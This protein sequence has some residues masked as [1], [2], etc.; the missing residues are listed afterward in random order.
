MNR[1]VRKEGRESRYILW[2]NFLVKDTRS[3]IYHH[4]RQEGVNHV[5]LLPT[6]T[7][8]L[9][10]HCFPLISAPA[11]QK[12]VLGPFGH[13][14]RVSYRGIT[15]SYWFKRKSLATHLAFTY[16][17]A[18]EKGSYSL[19][20]S[21]RLRLRLRRRS[22]AEVLVEGAFVLRAL[23]TLVHLGRRL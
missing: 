16:R 9:E 23:D 4:K 15:S 18:R 22:T 12:A 13:S 2:R 21:L 5:E 8:A 3:S 17:T 7:V 6:A 20:G 1:T 10:S 19:V 14:I 11:V